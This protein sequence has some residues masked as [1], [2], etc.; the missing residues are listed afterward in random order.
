MV[1]GTLPC[2][3]FD[4]FFPSGWWR[5]SLPVAAI[6]KDLE[7]KAK[8][9]A[10]VIDLMGSD[11]VS[12]NAGIYE[13]DSMLIGSLETGKQKSQVGALAEATDDV[14][15][16]YNEIIIIKAVKEEKGVVENLVAESVIETNFRRRA[17]GGHVFIF[18]RALS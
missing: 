18:G 4:L 7:I 15:I 3:S 13:Q 5:P 1:R 2:R 12:I 6:D 11:V 10:N 9:A 14:K 17:V 8:I 16:V